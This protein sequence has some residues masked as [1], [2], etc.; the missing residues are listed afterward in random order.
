MSQEVYKS[1]GLPISSPLDAVLQS[2]KTRIQLRKSALI[3]IDGGV[4]E[5]KTTIGVHCIDYFN[6]LYGFNP[7]II[8][9]PQ[10]A[11][12]GVDFLKKMRVCFNTKKPA[13][14]YDEA[15][16][17]S[18]RGSLSGFNAMINRT[19][20]TFRAFQCLVIIQLP[21]F[22]SLDQSLLDKNIPRLLLHLHDRTENSG[23]F[24][25]Y[26]LYGMQLL[27]WKMSKLP[28]KNY[29]YKLIHPNFYGNF[30]DLDPIRSKQLDKLST[31]SK[32]E[33]LRKNE[34]K[35]EGLLT[36]SEIGTKLFRSIHWVCEKVKELNI[37]PARVINR[38]RYFT[39]DALN[40]LGEEI[41]IV[42]DKG[43]WQLENEQGGG[44]HDRT[45]A[46]EIIDKDR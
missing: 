44:K 45:R 26:S 31:K 27:K 23:Y 19:F 39:S 25:A 16:D 21:S 42:N 1:N 4:G 30:K 13:I 24:D 22:N 37:Q 3:I 9:G 11:M 7:A 10:L 29:A 33:I 18:R 12:G 28:I 8:G 5:G 2:F 46:S 38:T 43:K 17:F 40:R 14:S 32:L 35:I 20:E 41:D 15:G 34:I 6:K 36:T